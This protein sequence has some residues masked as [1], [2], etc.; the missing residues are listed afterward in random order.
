MSKQSSI[1]D[2]INDNIITSTAKSTPDYKE[3]LQKIQN[4]IASDIL[5]KSDK[6][7]R[8]WL[9]YGYEP[10][11]E[12]NPNGN[13][14]GA[15]EEYNLLCYPFSDSVVFQSVHRMYPHSKPFVFLQE[16]KKHGAYTAVA[17]QFYKDSIDDFYQNGTEIT[18]EDILEKFHIDTHV[19]RIIYATGTYEE[20]LDI[21]NALVAW[22]R[23]YIQTLEAMQ[24]DKELNFM[25]ATKLKSSDK[26]S[27]S[28]YNEI[29]QRSFLTNEAAF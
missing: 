14:A 22:N 19:R 12:L 27:Y 3:L 26:K 16:C 13:A 25:R 29:T 23:Q 8:L 7:F 11:I 1:F 9:K 15:K 17:E 5:K 21:Q 6:Y 10:S 18:V 24:Q 2:F 28:P 20:C 4:Y